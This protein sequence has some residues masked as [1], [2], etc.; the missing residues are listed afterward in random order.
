[1]S[2]LEASKLYEAI[3][4]EVISDSRQDF[5]D[6]GVDESTLQDLR[7]IWCDKLTQSGVAKFSW[8][9][10]QNHYEIA[11]NLSQPGGGNAASNIGVLEDPLLLSSTPGLELSNIQGDSQLS[12]NTVGPGSGGIQIPIMTPTPNQEYYDNT[13]LMLPRINQS[14]GAFEFTVYPKD[15]KDIFESFKKEDQKFTKIR[16][17][18]GAEEEEDDDVFNESD[19]INSDLDDGLDTEKSDD[20]DN[21]QEGQIMLCLYEKVQRV[22]NKWKSSLKEGI[23]NI[24]GKDFVFQKATGENEW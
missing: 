13:G 19:D 2:N 6:S 5:E 14:D 7:R 23:A 1:M 10:E 16:Q 18:D 12:Y 9:D 11:G 22:K 24:N 21:D 17:V 15:S 4:E 3:I 20:D 8:D